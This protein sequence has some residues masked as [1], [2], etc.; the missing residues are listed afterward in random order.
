MELFTLIK[1]G[2]IAEIW[3]SR[4]LKLNALSTALKDVLIDAIMAL[5]ADEKIGVLI[6]SG[7]GRAFCVG[8]D[9]D[10]LVSCTPVAQ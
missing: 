10:E 5:E 2:E 1:K 9:R 3:L 4:P 8:S 7:T 6:I